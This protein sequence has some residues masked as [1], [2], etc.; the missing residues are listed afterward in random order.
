MF[1]V[2]WSLV[3]CEVWWVWNFGEVGVIRCYSC[4]VMV[5]GIMGCGVWMGSCD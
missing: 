2:V 1:K 3:C 4:F 5:I